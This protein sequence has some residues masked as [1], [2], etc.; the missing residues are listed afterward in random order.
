MIIDSDFTSNYHDV[1]QNVVTIN[2]CEHERI[3][4]Q[5]VAVFQI[6][7]LQWASNNFKLWL[8][9]DLVLQPTAL[10]RSPLKIRPLK[11]IDDYDRWPRYRTHGSTFNVNIHI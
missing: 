10:S 4:R 9:N 5:L 1:R 3:A 8:T 11:T 7:L 6:R 2:S